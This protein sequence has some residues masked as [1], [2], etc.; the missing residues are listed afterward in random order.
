MEKTRPQKAKNTYEN[1]LMFLILGKQYIDV[2]QK[3][4]I[5]NKKPDVSN[6]EVKRPN[7]SEPIRKRRDADPFSSYSS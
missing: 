2:K 5:N 7:K 3:N 1:D 4:D 6:S